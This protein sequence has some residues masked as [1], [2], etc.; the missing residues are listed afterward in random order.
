MSGTIVVEPKCSLRSGLVG[1]RE[2]VV[3]LLFDAGETREAT[4]AKTRPEALVNS[5]ERASDVL[6]C[7][8]CRLVNRPMY[9]VKDQSGCGVSQGSWVR[10]RT[11]RRQRI[12]AQ[13]PATVAVTRAQLL[14]QNRTI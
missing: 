12:V 5:T 10:N 8:K 3:L 14:M 6:H 1:L 11:S 7:C 9:D 13:T 4:V 2:S